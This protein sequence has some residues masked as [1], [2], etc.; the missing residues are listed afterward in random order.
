MK[1]FTNEI[2]KELGQK[3]GIIM[4]SIE[5]IWLYLVKLNG[6]YYQKTFKHF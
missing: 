5:R 1:I 3:D 4:H 6:F 2:P